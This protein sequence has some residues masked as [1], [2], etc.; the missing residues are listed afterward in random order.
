MTPKQR[1]YAALDHR[2]ADIVPYNLPMSPEAQEKLRALRGEE[3]MQ[4]IVNHFLGAGIDVM[5]K[6]REEGDT[7]EDLFG[8]VWRQG[9]IFHVL[10]APLPQPTLDG[11][12]FPDLT[13]PELYAHLPKVCADY[14]DRFIFS[15]VGMAFFER[16][17][18][19][20]GMQEI[21]IDLVQHPR[22]VEQLL[23][24]LM[25]LHFVV[26]D[27]ISQHPID[28]VYFGD[29]FGQQRGLIMGPHHWRRYLKPRLREMYACAKK[30]GFRVMIHSC[31]DVSEILP[32]LIEIGVDI[33]N[34]CQP[35]A[36]DLFALK[37]EYG[38]DITFNGG[39]GTQWL[40][41]RGT[42]QQVRDAVRDCIE[43]L[44]KDGGYVME[45]TKAVLPD[46]PAEN[47]AALY[48]AITQQ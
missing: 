13:R 39:I 28:A 12:Q 38:R 37:R 16:A 1:V 41:P 22:F 14:S 40:L 2:E 27:H 30:K 15:G 32:D 45:P 11:Y 36:M 31:G 47:V 29:D 6:A 46:V 26:I 34:P 20:R 7:F 17:W 21:L 43:K 9:N 23:D 19:L 5:R 18:A 42:P 25:E 24:R 33:L 3:A 44:G 4:G 8:T 35:E 10:R 48:D